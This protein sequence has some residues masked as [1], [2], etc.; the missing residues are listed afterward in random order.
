MSKNIG[1]QKGLGLQIEGST[2]AVLNMV[3]QG[4]ARSSDIWRKFERPKKYKFRIICLVAT[5]LLLALIYAEKLSS[6]SL[7]FSN[8][9]LLALEWSPSEQGSSTNSLSSSM[10]RAPLEP[11][12]DCS[13]LLAEVQ[14]GKSQI[15]DPNKG[16]SYIV[17]TTNNIPFNISL[18]DPKYDPV[19]GKMLKTFRYYERDLDTAWEQVL[20]ASPPG[21]RVLDAGGNIGYHTL[22]S[23]S[24]GKFQVDSFE[25][26]LENSLRFCESLELNGWIGESSSQL[27]SVNIN[28]F[29]VSDTDT[30]LRFYSS[31]WNPGAGKF[32][33]TSFAEKNPSLKH[34]NYTE[35]RVQTL[36]TFVEHRGWFDTKPN[37]AI[38]KID[39]ERHEAQAVLGA[40]KLLHS[41]LVQN[42]FIET[43]LDEFAEGKCPDRDA[44]ETLVNAGYVLHK[45]GGMQGP[46][47]PSLLPMDESLVDKLAVLIRKGRKHGYLNLWWVRPEVKV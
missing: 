7:Q 23:A 40:T 43:S 46:N 38:L 29:G 3:T 25:P 15:K 2:A 17:R 10:E 12:I 35:L 24:L 14:S 28:N 13:S 18:F 45:Y 26:K 19:R 41:A 5:G 36:D 37:I 33:A 39:V 20:R 9:E 4:K 42:I 22:L 21:S 32:V 34:Q 30:V 11:P 6:N 1:A 27:P 8:I 31:N 44:I 16:K 47:T